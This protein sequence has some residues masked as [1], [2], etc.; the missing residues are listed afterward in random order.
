MWD[1][2]EHFFRNFSWVD[3]VDFIIV[4][5]MVY[6]IYKWVKGT[7]A[8]SITLSIVGLYAF[9]KI[10]DLVNLR[11][12][13]GV[14]DKI[15]NMGFLAIIVIF[16]PEIRRFLFMLSNRPQNTIWIKKFLGRF[17]SSNHQDFLPLVQACMHLSASRT[18]ALIVLTRNNKLPQIISTGEYIDASLS[19]SLLE[20]IFFKNSPLHD[21]A[22]IVEDGR[23]L[24]ARCILP[25]TSSHDVL[26]D[27]G[28][29]HRAAI[30]I[31]EMTDSLA[32]VV[33]EETGSISYCIFGSLT[34]KVSPAQLQQKIDELM[35][36]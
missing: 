24:A 5:L 22:V 35:G 19:T 16:Q 6:Q 2:I 30:G 36:K 13:S 7:S 33:S 20:S 18:G 10:A 4:L 34:L 17:S 27:L 28:L 21:G 8:F 29:R 15:V 23:I 14:L 9:W 31:T 26:E 32:I 1:N 12:T 3:G 25:I 11:M